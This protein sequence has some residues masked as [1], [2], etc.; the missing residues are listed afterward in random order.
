MFDEFKIRVHFAS[1]YALDGLFS[2]YSIEV[3]KVYPSFAKNAYQI[4][5]FPRMFSP[6]AFFMHHPLQKNVSKSNIRGFH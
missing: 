5:V 4:F 1:K 2:W 3:L 6:V